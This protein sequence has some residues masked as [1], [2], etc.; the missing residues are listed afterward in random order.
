MTFYGHSLPDFPWD[1][2]VPDRERAAQHPQGTLD[3]T[4]GSPVDHTPPLALRALN[5]AGDGHGYPPVVG[6]PELQE[7]IRGWMER[8]RGI[9][10]ETG[11]VLS[12]GSKET[13]ALLP[14]MLGMGSG[15][16]VAFPEAAY[17]TYD[18][19]ARLA[20]AT[21]LTIDPAADPAS[22]PTNID[23]L[24]LNSPG[25]PNGHVLS[26]EQL[27]AIVAWA[28]EHDVV[29]ASDECY[30]A[31]CWDVQDAPS[32]LADDV[33]DGDVT[34]LLMLYSLSKQSNMAGYRAAFMAGDPALTKPIV[35]IRKHAGF[36]LPGPVQHAMAV[37]LA[38]DEH[39]AEQR[40]RYRKRREKLL[41]AMDLAGLVNDPE[42]VAGLYLW[43]G[44]RRDG[45]REPADAW[46]LTHACAELGI[47]VAP[48]TF[49]G[50]GGSH[51]IRISLTA[52]DETIEA[53][54]ARFADLP[55]VLAK[56]RH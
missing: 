29:V 7:S 46:T 24:W 23:L 18:V 12:I 32:I 30:A 45:D 3:L 48:G 1:T 27:R 14:S 49:Y 16:T 17:P 47:V 13:V 38:D 55:Q 28:R 2:L 51:R 9:T 8:R 11:V 35:E 31:L 20:G 40:E 39:V 41:A 26:R 21:P 22:W 44:E 19:G 53:A 5:D 34:N 37:M 56:Y 50:D 42:S 52:T 6:S 36:M 43:A 15:Q 4:I 33:C 25:N 10:S 54:A